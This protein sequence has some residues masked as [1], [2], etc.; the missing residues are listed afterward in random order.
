MVVPRI[1]RERSKNGI[2]HIMMRG[3]DKRWIFLQDQD[4]QRFME[5]MERAKRK[6]EMQVLAYCLMKNHIH[7]LIKEGTEGI[8]DTIRRIS[9]GYAQY[10]NKTHER[11]GHLF[12]NRFRS[13]AINDDRYLFTVF[14]YIHQ[15]PLKA[16]L[17]KTIEEY[18]WS[19]YHEYLQKKP[20]IVD[21]S[22]LW[23]KFSDEISLR[24]FHREKIEEGCLDLPEEIKY[25]DTELVFHI[26]KKIKIEEL[27]ALKPK[28][29]N[30]QIKM[31]RD[32][33][34][35]SIRQLAGVLKLGRNTVYRA[36]KE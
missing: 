24:T 7:L 29:R 31:I 23:T 16:G 11:T 2:Y 6:S 25:S 15:N 34:K 28:I 9:V 35:V 17:V 26:E 18:P 19:S 33:T 22:L 32:E 14:R 21:E 3:I 10:H 27:I 4:Y 30:Q 1:A 5:Y 20:Y 8:G 12:Q 36:V 13:E